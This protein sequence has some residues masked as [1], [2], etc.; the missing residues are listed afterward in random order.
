M[1]GKLR[2]RIGHPFCHRIIVM[3]I[4]LVASLFAGLF[5]GACG[6]KGPLYLPKASAPASAP[7]SKPASSVR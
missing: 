4:L 3:R 5:L 6:Y 1:D 7:I 2:C